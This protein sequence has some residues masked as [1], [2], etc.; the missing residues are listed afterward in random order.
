MKVLYIGNCVTNSI[1]DAFN[2]KYPDVHITYIVSVHL[3]ASEILTSFVNII[4]DQ[5]FIAVIIDFDGDGD[6]MQTQNTTIYKCIINIANKRNIKVILCAQLI[7]RINTIHNG[8]KLA[9]A[10]FK[11]LAD[12][13]TTHFEVEV[14]HTS[15]HSLYNKVYNHWSVK[16]SY[17]YI[18]GRP[19]LIPVQINLLVEL[20][21]HS[22]AKS[23]IAQ[24][25]FKTRKVYKTDIKMLRLS[26]DVHS[27]LCISG[28]GTML[29]LTHKRG[30]YVCNSFIY[31]RQITS[32]D[33]QCQ[34]IGD[35]VIPIEE[36]FKTELQINIPKEQKLNTISIESLKGTSINNKPHL[37]IINIVYIGSITSI[38]V[39]YKVLSDL[40]K[41][42]TLL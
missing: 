41:R 35:V 37:H 19:V 18:H 23:F 21:M 38:S 10:P 15:K 20:L 30:P 4:K 40:P 39:D 14:V 22:V 42:I 29:S 8:D 7:D 27:L 3:N 25:V 28:K 6:L 16:E 34:L 2:A 36:S 1:I 12:K 9:A 33:T 26:K 11:D 5:S 13:L 31:E 32:W 24:K 17:I